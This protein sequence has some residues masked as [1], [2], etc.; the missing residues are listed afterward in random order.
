MEEEE[1]REE[2]KEWGTGRGEDES[3]K[4]SSV[5]VTEFRRQRQDD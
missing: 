3:P 4:E 2:R 1:L 5:V